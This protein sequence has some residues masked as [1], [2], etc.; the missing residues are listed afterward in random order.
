M[1]LAAELLLRSRQITSAAE[2]N[3]QREQLERRKDFHEMI[4]EIEA[5]RIVTGDR[6]KA[7]AVRRFRELA[8]LLMMPDNDLEPDSGGYPW[9]FEYL[10]AREWPR[11][12]CDH[13][14]RLF[15]PFVSFKRSTAQPRTKKKRQKLLALS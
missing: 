1:T 6:N 3:W 2:T 13:L 7:R 15:P 5:A 9:F 11:G 14:K 8:E 4:P 12:W 10:E